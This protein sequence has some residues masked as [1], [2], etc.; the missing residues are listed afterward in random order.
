MMKPTNSRQGGDFE[1]RADILRSLAASRSLFV[2]AKMRAIAM[3]IRNVL[4]HEMPQMRFIDGDH[5]IEQIPAT[6]ANPAFSDAILPRTAKACALGLDTEALCSVDHR[7]VE[8]RATIEDQI[9]RSG[10]VRKRLANLLNNPITGRMLR[11]VEV[12]NPPPV[13]RDNEEAVQHPEGQRRHGEEV[14]RGDGLAM[15][16]EKGFPRLRLSRVAR[17]PAHPSQ[18]GPFRDVEAEHSQL[19]VNAWCAPGSVF[20]HHAEDEFPQFPAHASPAGTLPVARKPRP[21]E[22]E[23]GSMPANNRFGLNQDQGSPP[24]RPEAPQYNPDE[25]IDA[26]KPWPWTMSRED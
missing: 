21:I 12:Q 11:Y 17:S 2:E 5:M 24:T 22:P 7:L 19:S 14:H 3:V 26:R 15:I 4:I 10:I 9:P 25:A 8:I 16:V 18:H 23:A 13:V 20:G 1:T 6:V